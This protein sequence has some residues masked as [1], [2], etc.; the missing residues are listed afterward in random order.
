MEEYDEKVKI[1]IQGE[2]LK[3]HKNAGDIN[4][5]L[6]DFKMSYVKRL[7][8]EMLEG[9]LIKRQVD[10]E[11]EREREKELERK[12]KLDQNLQGFKKANEDIRNNKIKQR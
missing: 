12:K 4:Q 6:H 11:I 1:K 9:E 10:D 7:Q 2:F 5:Q 8:E 3:K